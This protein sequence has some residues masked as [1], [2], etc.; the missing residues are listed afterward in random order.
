MI[1]L[2]QTPAFGPISVIGIYQNLAVFV[3]SALGTNP[4]SLG[5]LGAIRTLY[6][7][8]RLEGQVRTALVA[9]RT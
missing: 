3:K 7:V 8:R 9:T 4:V 6:D 1:G 5:G 2:F